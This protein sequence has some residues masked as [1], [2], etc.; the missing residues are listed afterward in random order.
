VT[1]ECYRAEICLLLFSLL[2]PGSRL[3]LTD[4]QRIDKSCESSN[5][6][7][8]FPRKFP[9][10]KSLQAGL[11]PFCDTFLMNAKKIGEQRAVKTSSRVAILYLIILALV[12]RSDVT[13]KT[14]KVSAYLLITTKEGGVRENVLVLQPFF[15]SHQLDRHFYFQF[16]LTSPDYNT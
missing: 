4:K 11:L 3:K 7:S 1:S 5:H 6:K 2:T 9:S 8:C 16:H 14:E 15:A 13:R 12:P 10:R